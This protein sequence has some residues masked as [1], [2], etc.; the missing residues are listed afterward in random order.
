M[1]NFSDLVATQPE[2]IQQIFISDLHLAIEPA[3]NALEQA[4]LALLDICITLPNLQNL[5]IL[6]DWFEAWLGD[7]IADL[8]AMQKWFAPMLG[9]LRTLT[10]NQVK[11]CVM[12]GN[13]D[14]LLGQ[15]FC[16]SFGGELI[17]E[18]YY[19]DLAEKK[20]RLEH[21]DALCT[22]DKKYQYFR[23]VI[24]HPF[25]KKLLLAQSLSRRQQIAHNLRTK[26]K[27]DNAQKSMQIM[28]V[29][30]KAVENALQQ[31]A[32]LVHG[33]T[34]RPQFFPLENNKSRVV[35]GDWRVNGKQVEA[36]IGVVTQQTYKDVPI[37]LVKFYHSIS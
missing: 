32:S 13:R 27:Q 28:D 37:E 11:I 35:L 5:Y 18:P 33:H 23:K 10:Q 25:T 8:P 7:D 29:N 14:F 12:V 36:V 2:L 16:G 4:F 17:K 6:G 26:S 15:Q 30:K 21:G 1:Q 3:S 34:H 22:D 31:C 19:I 20:I 9:K 24:Q